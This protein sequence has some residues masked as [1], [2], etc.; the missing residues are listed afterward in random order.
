MQD[1]KNSATGTERQRKLLL[2]P[3]QETKLAYKRIKL[4]TKSGTP[5]RAHTHKNS[6]DELATD[7]T[8]IK[9][10]YSWGIEVL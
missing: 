9:N 3:S 2:N 7:K 4:M 10:L 1:N 8:T 6:C 5:T